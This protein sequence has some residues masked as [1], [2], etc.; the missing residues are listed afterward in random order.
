MGLKLPD[1][2]DYIFNKGGKCLPEFLMT[3]VGDKQDSSDL[4]RSTG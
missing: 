4:W 2:Q 3:Q 1:F